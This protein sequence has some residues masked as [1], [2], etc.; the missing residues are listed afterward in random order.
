LVGIGT[1]LL[2]TDYFPHL[3]IHLAPLPSVNA[4]GEVVDAEGLPVEN[5][6]VFVVDSP[7]ITKSLSNGSF[8]IPT[9][10]AAGQ[11]ITIRAK[12]GN[13]VTQLTQPSTTVFELRFENP[14]KHRP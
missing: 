3:V 5:A 9:H 4:H 2:A 13:E 1:A 14:R 7:D 8:E 6:V 12:R 11:P 10:V